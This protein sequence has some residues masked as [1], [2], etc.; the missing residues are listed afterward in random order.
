MTN[1][2]VILV[3]AGSEA[4]AEK[5][6]TF[7]VEERLAACVNILNPIR[8]FYRWQGK[9]ANDREWLLIIKTQVERF[10]AVE[11][12]VKALHSYEVPE[13]IALPIRAGSEDYLRW[14]G[15]ETIDTER[16]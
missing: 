2:I 14:L 15:N 12:K 3:T 1:Y 8:S 4:E 11:A 10:A 5:I 6:A 7:L 9:V 16:E 13:V